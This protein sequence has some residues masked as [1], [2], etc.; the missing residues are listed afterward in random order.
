MVLTKWKIQEN[1]HTSEL[2]FPNLCVQQVFSLDLFSFTF[3]SLSS[4]FLA[5]SLNWDFLVQFVQFNEVQLWLLQGLDL[6]DDGIAQVV[7]E[8]AGLD[9]SLGEVILVV[10]LS[11]EVRQVGFGSFGIDDFGDLLSDE[12]DLLM[13]GITGLSDLVL[14]LAS[15][16]GDEDSQNIT[17]LSLDF[18]VDVDQSLPFSNILAESISGHI[19]SVEVGD[20]GSSLDVFDGE[21]DLS[22]EIGVVVQVT[23]GGFNDSSLQSI[24]SDLCSGGSGDAGLSDVSSGEW[25]WGLNIVP[26]LSEEGIL[27]L[28]LGTLLL[29][30][31]FIFSDS[32][33]ILLF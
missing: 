12:L 17:I 24:G 7:D 31:L 21:L 20:A 1:F 33:K 18:A 19:E 13:L 5:F 32:H 8:S 2:Y 30:E 4:S 9:D 14:L 23:E 22:P 27:S 25:S 10:E 16:S 11:D 28:L 29:A 26:F 15:E 3:T 6:S